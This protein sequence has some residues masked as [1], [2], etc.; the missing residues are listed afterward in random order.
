MFIVVSVLT[1]GILSPGPAF[2]LVVD[3]SVAH[4]RSVGILAAI[5]IAITNALIAMALLGGLSG[6]A[7]HGDSLLKV[8]QLLGLSYLLL[9][10]TL[11]LAR[12]LRALASPD[13]G[14]PGADPPQLTESRSILVSGLVR[15][16]VVQAV[17]PKVWIFF[18]SAMF[19]L[20]PADW[21]TAMSS[22]LVSLILVIS[23]TWYIALA[24]CIDLLVPKHSAPYLAAGSS[25]ALLVVSVWLIFLVLGTSV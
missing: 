7:A 12:G 8:L 5:G 2:L 24:T 6:V 14:T 22:V 23:L 13:T 9:I 18:T 4:G 1:M 3:V 11:G 20:A 10:A 15:G 17:N 21:T 16:A 25:L 19:G